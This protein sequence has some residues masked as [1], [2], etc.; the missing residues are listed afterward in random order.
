[1]YGK[2]LVP[3]ALLICTPT[4]L[5]A[6][7]S[8][9]P[10]QQGRI[11]QIDR[12]AKRITVRIEAYNSKGQFTAHGSG[13]LV[14]RKKNI[15]TLL[16]AD[17]VLHYRTKDGSNQLDGTIKGSRFQIITPDGKKYPIKPNSI[18]R[19]SVL[20][21]TTFK[22]TSNKSYQL[23]SIA[24]TDRIAYSFSDRDWTFVAGYPD[25]TK[26]NRNPQQWLWYTSVGSYIPR[27]QNFFA[28]KNN[29]SSTAGY[30]LVYNN[31]TYG[32]MS[33]GA[34]LNSQGQLIGI[35][36]RQEDLATGY[37][38]S[39]GVPIGVFNSLTSALGVDSRALN[40]QAILPVLSSQENKVLNAQVAQR[41][42]TEL[43]NTPIATTEYQWLRKGVQQ[44]RLGQMDSAITSLNSAIKLQPKLA[45]AYYT[46]GMIFS[47]NKPDAAITEF[48]RAI[49]YCNEYLA[50]CI[51]ALREKS[52]KAIYN[53]EYTIALSSINKAIE[54]DSKEAY[55]H[56]IKGD[57]LSKLKRFPAAITSYNQAIAISPNPYFYYDRGI[58]YYQSGNKQQG[59]ADIKE[60]FKRNP[61]AVQ[62]YMTTIADLSK[63]EDPIIIDTL[64][65]IIALRPQLVEAYVLRGNAY[66]LF[67]Q[68]N[69]S[70]LDYQTAKKLI[71][72]GKAE[73]IYTQD[74]QAQAKHNQL[75]LAAIYKG[76]A[77]Y[78][79]AL[80]IYDR[81]ITS[82][83][84]NPRN[85]FN[86]GNLLA[87]IN[88]YP[89]ALSDYNRAISIAPND[90]AYYASRSSI[91]EKLNREPE[92]L[93]DL[94]RQIDILTRS[95]DAKSLASA[96]TSR[97]LKYF[98]AGNYAPALIDC[99]RAIDL[100]RTYGIAY[101]LR[102]GIYSRVGNNLVAI[103]NETKYI[104]LLEAEVNPNFENAA[105]FYLIPA[106]A[107]R[108]KYYQAI[109][110]TAEAQA[111]WQKSL[112]FDL[113]KIDDRDKQISAYIA[114]SWVNQNLE[115]Y[116]EAIA[117]LN[118]VIKLDPKNDAAYRDRG[119]AKVRLN[120]YPQAVADFS[121]AI[122]L[123]PNEGVTYFGR[124]T[125]YVF[126]GK[127]PAALLDIDRAI[128]LKSP[129]IGE[130]QLYT[131]RAKIY[132]LSGDP[133]NSIKDLDRVIKLQPSSIQYGARGLIYSG[134]GQYTQAM[135]DLELAVG[136]EK[137]P[138][139]KAEYISD[140]GSCYFQQGKYD[141]ALADY[142]TALKLDPKSVINYLRLGRVYYK[143]GKYSEALIAIDTVLK[144]DPNQISPYSVA[145]YSLM[146]QIRLKQKD[147]P[148]ARAARD[149]MIA[150]NLDNRSTAIAS[151]KNTNLGFLQYDLGEIEN[152]MSN[153]KR[154]IKLNPG[155]NYES[156]LAMAS[157]LYSQGKIN[158]AI[159]LA[160]PILNRYP[161]LRNPQYLNQ[162][163]WSS[164][165][166]TLV[167]KMYG[168][169]QVNNIIWNVNVN[170]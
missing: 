80:A 165:L 79:Q 69:L 78:T 62:L 9:T 64:S 52:L 49:Q 162:S 114:R 17:H 158:E 90:A 134:L 27:E 101:H 127:Y 100:N 41:Q 163:L 138:I 126:L 88:R 130:S 21:L 97:S 120:Q 98:I 144:L 170:N 6:T 166:L 139:E 23:A 77:E 33:G 160:K 85:Y 136:L 159:L 111:D 164:E 43:D 140:R 37:G 94:S 65:T 99:N 113:P 35:H 169:R 75:V 107:E 87:K 137:D 116:P 148:K 4:A 157:V 34:V 161:H 119:I 96:Y 156:Q 68:N 115:R 45:A 153:W 2:Y 31:L 151:S 12:V 149:R 28:I 15:Y 142:N 92:S 29:N 67:Y 145:A 10:P 122:A 76:L 7:P 152:A 102:A 3:I 109:G 55:L 54:L 112:K 5:A 105:I 61:N 50:V 125:A 110:K 124:S 132:A 82:D 60:T 56:D 72:S 91:Y 38:L 104:E 39:L 20:D 73:F 59:I 135:K 58:A 16:T 84:K 129:S 103:A 108:G 86:R 118:A 44:I 141:L 155:T 74:E 154:S 40:Y 19:Q 11:A 143:F 14:S 83:P 18:R 123:D 128:Q 167:K 1:M 57:I 63:V 24:A 95:N 71:F 42:K 131:S 133:T 25:P 121:A 22:I 106:Y 32:G 147:L 146:G 36:G 47:Q 93:A 70:K 150:I 8:A 117:D 168:D 46:K 30:E 89:A 48:D 53:G 66:R 81:S 13:V 26:F 51:P